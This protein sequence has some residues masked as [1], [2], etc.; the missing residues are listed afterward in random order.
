MPWSQ[1]RFGYGE[2]LLLA[3]NGHADP[4]VGCPLLSSKADIGESAGNSERERPADSHLI[5]PLPTFERRT[6]QHGRSS[7]GRGPCYCG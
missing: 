3:Q 6:P 2:H 5:R 7:R 4:V 1:F